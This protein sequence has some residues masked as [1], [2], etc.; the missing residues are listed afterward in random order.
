MGF[1]RQPNLV[2]FCDRPFPRETAQNLRKNKAGITAA[3][4]IPLSLRSAGSADQI[5]G[6]QTPQVL[7]GLTRTRPPHPLVWAYWETDKNLDLKN[8]SLERWDDNGVSDLHDGVRSQTDDPSNIRNC[9][10]C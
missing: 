3:L 1:L 9:R 8:R 5:S 2:T 6:E 10:Q 4:I 7:D